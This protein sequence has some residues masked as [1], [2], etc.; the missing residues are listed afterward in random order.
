MSRRR[1]AGASRWS[2]PRPELS[3]ALDTRIGGALSDADRQQ[4]RGQGLQR[5]GARGGASRPRAA[6]SGSA[7]PGGRGCAHLERHGPARD[8]ARVRATAIVGAGAAAVVGR[9]G[10]AGRR[11]LRAHHLFRG[12]RLPARHRR[13]DQPPAARGQ[14]DAG[15]RR[16]VRRAPRGRGPAGCAA[17]RRRRG[18]GAVRRCDVPLR[19]PRRRRSTALSR[20]RS[21]RASGSA[22]SGARAPARRPSSS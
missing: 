18:R 10:D 19:R 11:R 5:G 20:W 21:R 13:A 12:P 8:P 3:N 15:P 14:R 2:R 1:D 16:A 4:R 7:A 17:A 6:A 9:A 22:S